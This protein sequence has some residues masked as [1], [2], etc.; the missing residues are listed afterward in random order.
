MKRGIGMQRI[1]QKIVDARELAEKIC[2]IQNTCDEISFST[3]FDF[4]EDGVVLESST[5]DWWG[6]KFMGAF[7]GTFLLFGAFGGRS[8]Y[9]YDTD[10]N[11][12]TEE[13][14]VVIEEM[15]NRISAEKVCVEEAKRE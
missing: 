11:M 13:I 9:A 3:C 14:Q 7:D 4:D 1:T 12:T 2:A 10:F 6:A 8:W 15:F 5:G